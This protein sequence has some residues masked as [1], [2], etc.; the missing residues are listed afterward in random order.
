MKKF[1]RLRN[2]IILFASV[3]GLV[4]FFLLFANQLVIS[5]TNLEVD[6]YRAFFNENGAPLSFVGYLM[7]GVASLAGCGL[8][9][10]KLDANS[11]KMVYFALSVIMI[12][13]AIFAMLSA[14]ICTGN[15]VLT[16]NLASGP[17]CAGI[18]GIIA[19]LGYCV[20]QFLK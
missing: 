17:I 10:V 1:L 6:Y 20:A 3:F 9:F 14:A 13:G 15:S 18:F 11:K 19:G 12:L 2:L 5:D 4:A 8:V 16:Y 7:M